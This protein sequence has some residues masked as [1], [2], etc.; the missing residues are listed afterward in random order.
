M[1][2]PRFI[3]QT[4]NTD[5]YRKKRER[6]VATKSYTSDP[7]ILGIE[8]VE[9][10]WQALERRGAIENDKIRSALINNPDK[11]LLH[12]P[13]LFKHASIQEKSRP[14]TIKP[15]S[16]PIP[17][18][19]SRKHKLVYTRTCGEDRKARCGDSSALLSLSPP[20]FNRS[21]PLGIADLARY[22]FSSF[23]DVVALV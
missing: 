6:Y 19:P 13:T 20:S 21:V 14:V 17:I 22:R 1:I 4:I 5:K 10:F 7:L 15:S 16:K 3:V 2:I 12:F 9:R 11:G 18:H 23:Q 8:N